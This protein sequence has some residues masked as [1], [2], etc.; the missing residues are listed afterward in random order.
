VGISSAVAWRSAPFLLDAP[1]PSAPAQAV[2]AAPAAVAEAPA[3]K[4]GKGTIQIFE[5]MVCALLSFLLVRLFSHISK[6][7]DFWRSILLFFAGGSLFLFP[8]FQFG[9]NLASVRLSFD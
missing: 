1:P 4:N 3:A 9:M 8:F 5:P 6:V 7:A 2:V